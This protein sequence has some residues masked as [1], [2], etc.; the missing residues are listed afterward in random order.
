MS[1]V[2]AGTPEKMAVSAVVRS[3][4]TGRVVLV[5]RKNPP[6]A[7]QWSLPGGS[8]EPG[9]TPAAALK[10]ELYEEL[11]LDLPG[12]STGAP[13][14]KVTTVRVAA[15]PHAYL[16]DVFLVELAHEAVLTPATDAAEATW[17]DASTRR[18]LGLAEDTAQ[19]V[20]SVCAQ[21]VSR[22]PRD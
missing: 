19:I 3:S 2:D 5:R 11:G 14:H 18:A 1:A 21:P 6:R 20:D 16:I 4:D 9:E 15:G 22:S 13:G 12:P 17:T 8:V 10:R 7:G